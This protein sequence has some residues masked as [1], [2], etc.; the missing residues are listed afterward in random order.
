M[1]MIVAYGGAF[2]QFE[3]DEGVESENYTYCTLL[4]F[5]GSQYSNSHSFWSSS[6]ISY[7][8][9]FG[10]I[11]RFVKLTPFCSF[12][13]V[14]SDSLN[15]IRYVIDID[16][17]RMEYWYEWGECEKC[18]YSLTG[19]FLSDKDLLNFEFSANK[20]KILY[21]GENQAGIKIRKMKKF[22][23]SVTCENIEILACI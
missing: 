13:F 14:I 6:P 22:Y 4:R 19:E 17:F 8:V 15:K 16:N 9:N 5:K 18:L 10:I 7:G 1:K 23:L 2:I 3:G 20:L 11:F 12:R 21:N